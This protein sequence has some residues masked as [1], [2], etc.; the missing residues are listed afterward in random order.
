MLI[1]NIYVNIYAHESDLG[2][3][4]ECIMLHPQALKGFLGVIYKTLLCVVFALKPN[5]TIPA[6]PFVSKQS[7]KPG[8]P[9]SGFGAEH[10]TEGV[11][12]YR[13]THFE[14]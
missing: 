14:G 8:R 3:E 10:R 4:T 13:F 1:Y 2:R 11:S 7:A 5:R 9:A 6:I 12:C